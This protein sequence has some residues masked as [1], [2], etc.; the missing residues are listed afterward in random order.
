M[1]GRPMTAETNCLDC[2]G[3]ITV[4]FDFEAPEPDIGF[5][6]G[7]SVT[8]VEPN[9]DCECV[10]PRSDIWTDSDLIEHAEDAAGQAML[11]YNELEA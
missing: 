2:P 5:R 10:H 3:S 4:T 1:G 7:C 11:T 9:D 6:G 8:E